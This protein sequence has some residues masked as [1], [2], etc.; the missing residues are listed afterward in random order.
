MRQL[1][2]VLLLLAATVGA[3]AERTRGPS[4]AYIGGGAGG[5]VARDR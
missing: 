2:A 3:C 1:L 4:G 5:N